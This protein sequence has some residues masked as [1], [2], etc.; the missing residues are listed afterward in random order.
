MTTYVVTV[1]AEGQ[2]RQWNVDQWTSFLFFAVLSAEPETWD[3]WDAALRRY[4]PDHQLLREDNIIPELSPSLFNT[5]WCLIDGTGRTAVLGGGFEPHE[6]G[7]YR[8]EDDDEDEQAVLPEGN[9][10]TSATTNRDS[11]IAWVAIPGDWLI[12]EATDGWEQV[13]MHREAVALQTPRIESRAVLY[14]ESLHRFLAERVM[15]AEGVASWN[16][17]EEYR[18]TRKIHVDWLMT[19]REDLLGKIPRDFLH[20]SREAIQSDLENRAHQWSLQ[21]FPPQGLPDESAAYRYG[22][23]GTAEVVLYFEMIRALLE[24]AW[25]LRRWMITQQRPS[26]EACPS[27]ETPPRSVEELTE[28]LADFAQKWLATPGDEDFSGLSPQAMMDSERRRMPIAGSSYFDH[29]GLP[30]ERDL[31][32]RFGPSFLWFDGHHLELEDEFAFS[33]ISCPE[34]WGD[35]QGSYSTTRPAAAEE[36]VA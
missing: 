24:E 32:G 33:L 23:W 7:R 30:S 34:E 26:P 15:A 28:A 10:E 35:I 20:E 27:A 36:D 25:N 22:G 3:D 14:G 29:E 6:N 19:P 17:E 4:L 9:S 31:R 13:L 11:Q 18:A 1:R 2:L 12:T 5:P 21:G 16:S 8:R